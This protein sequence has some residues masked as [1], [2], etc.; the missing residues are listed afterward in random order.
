MLIVRN[1]LEFMA[2]ILIAAVIHLLITRSGF[3]TSGLLAIVLVAAWGKTLFFGSENLQQLWKASTENMAYH[4]FMV[5]MLVNMSQIMLSFGLDFFALHTLNSESFSSINKSLNQMELVFEFF[6]FSVLNF[7]FF[8]YGDITP[9][10]VPAKLLTM[11]E[12]ILAFVTVIFLLSDFISLKESL[13]TSG[14]R[15]GSE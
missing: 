9:Q 4:R 10:T 14:K 6:Y 2:L 1:L 3:V 12:V 8:G 15:K 11:T 7:T 13:S 5:L